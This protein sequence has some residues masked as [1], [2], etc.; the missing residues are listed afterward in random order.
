MQAFKPVVEALLAPQ[1]ASTAVGAQK[2]QRA[3]TAY[4]V[5]NVP[6]DFHVDPCHNSQN[7]HYIRMV[8]AKYS[9]EHIL[10]MVCARLVKSSDAV[11]MLSA[12]SPSALLVLRPCMEGSPTHFFT[13]N[14][15]LCTLCC[16]TP[17]IHA[18]IKLSLSVLFSCFVM[19]RR[20]R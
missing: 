20:R 17:Y 10:H 1:K 19:T 12:S 8:I 14:F 15:L 2:G 5:H 11:V 9:S 6:S 7:C 13:H 16:A 3:K 4:Q 18:C